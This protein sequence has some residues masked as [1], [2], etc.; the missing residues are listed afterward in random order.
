MNFKRVAKAKEELATKLK[1]QKNKEQ[2]FNILKKPCSIN[3][4]CKRADN[5]YNKK[6]KAVLESLGIHMQQE[7]NGIP[8]FVSVASVLFDLRKHLNIA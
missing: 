7:I 5:F 4:F 6:E 8:C 1:E 3:D 2:L